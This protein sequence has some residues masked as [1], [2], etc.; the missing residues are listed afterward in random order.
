MQALWQ[1]LLQNP[2]V[3]GAGAW[4]NALPFPWHR[5]AVTLGGRTMRAPC[6]DRWLYLQT[7]RLFAPDAFLLEVLRPMCL[8]GGTALDLGAN[9]G[10]YTLAFSDWVGPNGNVF[11]FEAD[12]VNHAALTENLLANGAANVRALGLAAG[13]A[14]APAYLQRSACNSGDHRVRKTRD[15]QTALQ[16]ISMVALDE[17]LHDQFR[18]DCVKLDIQGGEGRALRGMRG[19]LQA[20]PRLQGLLEFWPYGLAQ[21]GEDPVAI[22]ADLIDLRFRLAWVDEPRRRLE[23]LPDPGVL[24]SRLPGKRYGHVVF[25]G[26]QAAVGWAA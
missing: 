15:G 23:P 13:D 8:A 9:L 14:T 18:V 25:A 4:V 2:W 26:P 21:A 19:L 11:A 5:F 12:P 20:N 24:P 22:L 3:A 17:F 10:L 6:L 1:N 7:H 16:P